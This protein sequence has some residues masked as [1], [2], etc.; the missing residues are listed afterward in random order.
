MVT[1]LADVASG[2]SYLHDQGI[3]HGNVD[4]VRACAP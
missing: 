3:F 2:L 4:G 1:Q